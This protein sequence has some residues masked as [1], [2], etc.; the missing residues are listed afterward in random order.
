MI[1][2]R[3][4]VA[5]DDGMT[6]VEVLVTIVIGM[7][8]MFAALSM[9]DLGFNSSARVQDRTDSAAR[10]R[11][12]FDR[13]TSLLQAQVCNGN[14]PPV[15]AGTTTAVTFTANTGDRAAAPVQYQLRYD[16]PSGAVPGRLVERRWQM[17]AAPDVNGV[18]SAVSFTDRTIVEQVE[19]ISTGPPV[20]PVFRYY[21]TNDTTTNTPVELAAPLAAGTAA[22]NYI[23]R[24]LRV[25]IDLRV[26]P[27][28]T[29]SVAEAR[30]LS[31]RL[32][33]SAYVVSSLDPTKL[34]K[35]PQCS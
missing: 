12:A 9:M 31:S 7:I 11:Q 24:V 3:T 18:Y 14:K 27:S 8:V 32:Q 20:S 17:S 6:L 23:G 33:A 13:A 25:D 19:P 15:V 21:G 29:R 1:V 16:P 22:A 35:G 10:G 26:L 4:R 28:R 2:R 5:A 30:R 34:D